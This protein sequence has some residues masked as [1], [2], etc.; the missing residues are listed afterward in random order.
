MRRPITQ[1]DSPGIEPVPQPKEPAIIGGRAE[2][3]TLPRPRGED[4]RYE[5][6]IIRGRE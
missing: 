5:P 3:W 4:D 6:T 2:T 1:I